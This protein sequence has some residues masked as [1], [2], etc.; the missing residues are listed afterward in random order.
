MKRTIVLPRY[1]VIPFLNEECFKFN[2]MLNSSPYPDCPAPAPYDSVS[3]VKSLFEYSDVLAF[4]QDFYEEKKNTSNFSYKSFAAK[5]GHS[6]PNYFKLV[7]DGTRKLTVSN[8]HSFA[9][10]MDLST[11]EIDYFETLVLQ[12]QSSTPLEKSYY[13]KRLKTL[14]KGHKDSKRDSIERKKPSSELDSTLKT[15]MILL[16]SGRTQSDAQKGAK[17]ELNLSTAASEAILNQLI[18]DQSLALDESGVFRRPARH[19]VMKDPS[20]LSQR[21]RNFLSDGMIEAQKVFEERY[22]KG[23]AKFL[24]LL[25]TAPKG[26]LQSLFDD[27]R[28]GAED[29]VNKHDPATPEDSVIYRVQFQ[30]YPLNKEHS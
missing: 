8:I 27:V 4:F 20:G 11:D 1:L 26:S 23:S 10:A 29:T 30:V 25:C 12:N 21:Q 17:Q 3:L 5:A 16:A 13:S 28:I 9:K 24:S 19:T 2:K 18:Q 15:V 6:S 14:K 22:P 7:M